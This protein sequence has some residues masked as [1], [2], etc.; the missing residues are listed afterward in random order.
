MKDSKIR[1]F[2]TMTK[3]GNKA[4]HLSLV[5]K[6]QGERAD[7]C[8]ALSLLGISY[9]IPQAATHPPDSFPAWNMWSSRVP[10]PTATS[11][12]SVNATT[13]KRKATDSTHVEALASKRVRVNDEAATS[14]GSPK[15]ITA[16]ATSASSISTRDPP[17]NTSAGS[18]YPSF[19]K[20]GIPTRVIWADGGGDSVEMEDV[21]AIC[22]HRLSPRRY[23][24]L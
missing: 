13:E 21:N 3:R 9:K 14:S 24:I 1:R 18:K 5:A 2:L 20:K 11:S 4:K 6:E 15:L 17:A 12:T 10:E 22:T 23:F 7:I 19:K 16:H 8:N